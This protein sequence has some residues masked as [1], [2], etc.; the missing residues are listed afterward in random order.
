MLLATFLSSINHFGLLALQRIP[1]RNESCPHDIHCSKHTSTFWLW[2]EKTFWWL[3][4]DNIIQLFSEHQPSRPNRRHASH[5]AMVYKSSCIFCLFCINCVQLDNPI[6]QPRENRKLLS[7][8]VSK[9]AKNSVQHSASLDVRIL[10]MLPN[11]GLPQ[12]QKW[13][14]FQSTICSQI[15]IESCCQ[16]SQWSSVSAHRWR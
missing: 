10:H 16:P 9:Q 12:E 2:K 7:I 15:N 3:C 6:L 14:D 4:G 1:T 13:L 8:C 11:H 5:W